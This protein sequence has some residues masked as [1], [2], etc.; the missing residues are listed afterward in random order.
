[1]ENFATGGVGGSKIRDQKRIGDEF[2]RPFQEFSL[3][4][5][6]APGENSTADAEKTAF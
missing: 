3:T 2:V 5:F 6:V 4:A 1:M